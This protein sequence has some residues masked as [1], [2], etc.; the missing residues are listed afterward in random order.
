MLFQMLVLAGIGAGV[1]AGANFGW[2]FG[3]VAV[4]VGGFLGGLV[5]LGVAL[6]HRR[7]VL[8]V[9]GPRKPETKSRMTPLEERI[10][11]PI[12]AFG[13]TFGVMF[14]WV[15]TFLTV[16]SLIPREPKPGELSRGQCL[17]ISSS[18]TLCSYLLV[19]GARKLVDWVESRHEQAE[20]GC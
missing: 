4:L 8:W 18:V 19:W 10:C 15:G 12:Y 5:G 2:P 14:S 20:K 16:A 6:L 13:M 1:F 17:L 3:V 7:L 11:T 9:L